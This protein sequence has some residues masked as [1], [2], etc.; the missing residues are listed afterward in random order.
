MYVERVHPSGTEA[1]V[2]S[3]AP[4]PRTI[5]VA[6]DDTDSRVIARTILEARGHSVLEVANG[7]DCVDLAREARPD[8]V[9]LDLQMPV[10]DGFGAAAQLRTHPETAAVPILAATAL[11]R[12][13]DRQRALRAGCDQV[14]VKPFSPMKLVIRA[15]ELVY[16]ARQAR[17]QAPGLARKVDDAVRMPGGIFMVRGEGARRRTNGRA[18]RSGEP[19]STTEPT[20]E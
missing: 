8:L 19:D 2:L 6:D 12:R 14:I 1:A 10:L 4:D 18:S 16:R 9:V 7:R 15:E 3:I 17:G 20:L 13:A 5:L 11:A